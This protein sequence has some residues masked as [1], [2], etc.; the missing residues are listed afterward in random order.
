MSMTRHTS[1]TPSDIEPQA[2]ALLR[3]LP[4]GVYKTDH[5]GRITYYNEAAAA[6]W[7]RRPELGESE[8]FGSWKL[9][10]SD[11]API[12]IEE[13]PSA[14]ALRERRQIR[15]TAVVAERPDGARV[16]F[17]SAS[18]LQFD[19]AGNLTGAVTTMIAVEDRYHEELSARRYVAIVES[20]DDAILSKNLDGVITSWNRGAQK[21]FGYTADEVVGKSVTI[22]IPAERQDEEPSILNRIRRGE[23]IDH[24]ETVRQRKDGG[25]IDISLTV[26]PIKDS[27]GRIVGASKIARDITDRKR[28]QEQQRLLL[29]E[30][31][32]RVRNL[33]AISSGLVALS[34]R[35]ATTPDELATKVRERLAALAQAH[36]LLLSKAADDS[37]GAAS[38]MTLQELIRTIILPYDDLQYGGTSRVTIG[39]PDLTLS[40]AELTGL[41]LLLHEFA[42]NAAKYGALSTAAGTIAI[43]CSVK[44]DIVVLEWTER[45]GPRVAYRGESEGFGSLLVRTTV[46]RQL[47]GDFEQVWAPEG[48]TITLSIPRDRIAG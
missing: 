29:R 28:A 6:L 18:A 41:A 38:S 22:L 40:G 46:K 34:A 25:L 36:V 42:T 10:C 26:S 5:E 20:S 35:S 37:G 13:W 11:G 30:M 21:L 15:A 44:G 45:G 4:A 47:G 3:G 32:H 39:G 23:R 48:L 1:V 33:F 9:I 31:D 8:F 27:F 19:E 2:D 14:I 24:Y 43:M 16:S 17:I 7:G 12:P